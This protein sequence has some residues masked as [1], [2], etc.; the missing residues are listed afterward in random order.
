MIPV[1]AP[2][3]GE[4]E[5]EWVNRAVSSGWISGQGEYV[6]AF[7]ER[8]AEVCG[9]S[10]GIS[11]SSGT[12]ALETAVHALGIPAGT[13]IILPSFTMISCLAAVLRNDL[14]PVFIDADPRTWC[15]DVRRIEERIGP[16]T[17]GIMVVHTYGHPVDMQPVRSLAERHGLRII[18][19]ASEAHGARCHGRICGGFGDVSAFSF[20]SNK[21][22]VTGEGGMVVCDDDTVAEDCRNYRNLYYDRRYR[23]LHGRLGQNFRLTNVQAAIGCAQV[24]KLPRALDRKARMAAL[25]DELLRDVPDLQL[26]PRSDWCDNVFWI[27]GV[28]LGDSHPIDAPELQVRLR[29]AGVDSRLFFLGMHEQPITRDLGIARG[30]RYPVTERLSRRG[31]CLPSGLTITED[32][33]QTVTQALK[34]CLGH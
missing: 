6:R 23:F 34:H 30:E 31:L 3:L 29:E 12:A 27:Y 19:N 10:Y 16:R 26:P 32:E 28:V 2:W 21:I 1:N 20:Y 7:E 24:E 4:E 15:M 25:Y 14:V 11:V 9:R 17:T 8:W 18:E 5:A 22:V 13:E 33:I